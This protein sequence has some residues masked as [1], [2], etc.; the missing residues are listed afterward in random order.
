M[1]VL[2]EQVLHGQKIFA[3]YLTEI[4]GGCNV[5]VL[6]Q[7]RQ[8]GFPDEDIDHF[9][10]AVV[11]CQK[12]LDNYQFLETLVPGQLTAKHFGHATGTDLIEQQVFVTESSRFYHT[13]PQPRG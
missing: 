1:Q 6:E 10:V 8:T 4:V 2:A 11:L 5:I 3:V 12:F 7:G 9:P 13:H